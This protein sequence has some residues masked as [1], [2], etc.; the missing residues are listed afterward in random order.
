[1]KSKSDLVLLVMER[2]LRQEHRNF[3]VDGNLSKVGLTFMYA[4]NAL[5]RFTKM[6]ESELR[7]QMNG[8]EAL[9]REPV[10][11]IADEIDA[12]AEAAG[13]V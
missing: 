7:M 6:S 10:R 1:M 12:F 2:W 5:E 11:T 13:S 8:L 3:G 4:H 9:L